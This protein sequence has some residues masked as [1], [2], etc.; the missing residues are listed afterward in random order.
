M[1]Y[2]LLLFLAVV[3]L[4]GCA[5]NR[6]VPAACRLNELDPAFSVVRGEERN[7]LLDELTVAI[8]AAAVTRFD[9][10]TSEQFIVRSSNRAIV[11]EL[12]SCLPARWSFERVN[13][14]WVYQSYDPAICV[15]R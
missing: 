11:C 13:G 5:T 12:S 6:Q 10:Q 15:V 3:A 2:F 14:R 1:R 7:A 9:R 8:D 4:D